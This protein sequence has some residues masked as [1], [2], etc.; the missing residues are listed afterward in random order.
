MKRCANGKKNSAGSSDSDGCTDAC[1]A[2][3][4]CK[5]Y[6]THRRCVGAGLDKLHCAVIKDAAKNKYIKDGLV[7]DCMAQT[8]CKAYT[9][10]TGHEKCL[11]TS[12]D[13][14]K[15]RTVADASKNKYI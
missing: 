3:P 1:Y 14:K 7:V 4:E 13:T 6:D 15:C 9:D 2:Q 5:T 12:K 8:D 10:V 11:G